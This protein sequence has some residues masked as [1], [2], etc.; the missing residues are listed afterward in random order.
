MIIVPHT[1][2]DIIR[3]G[4]LQRHCVGGYAA[5]HM[6]GKLTI[7]FLRKTDEPETPLYTIEMHDK[8]L[9][10]VQGEGNRTPLTPEAKIFFD[11]WLK[12]VKGGSRRNKKGEPIIKAIKTA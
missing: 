12:W 9:T 1:V 10:Q 8:H 5:R 3:E 4:K 7:C 2:A 6:D 11:R